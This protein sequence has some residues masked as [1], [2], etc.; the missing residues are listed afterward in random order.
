M[1]IKARDNSIKFIPRMN[2]Q[3]SFAYASL[4]M[5]THTLTAL[6]PECT[7]EQGRCPHRR[8]RA[9]TTGGAGRRTG[10]TRNAT[11]LW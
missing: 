9:G 1:H 4:T 2:L 5:H 7:K 11:L 3:L 10:H 6:G 8:R